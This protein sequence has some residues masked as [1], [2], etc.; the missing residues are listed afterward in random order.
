MPRLSVLTGALGAPKIGDDTRRAPEAL[1]RQSLSPG[2]QI[3]KNRSTGN[4]G[5]MGD[6][7]ER[8]RIRFSFDA[9]AAAA[10]YDSMSRSAYH[11]TAGGGGGVA[12]ENE[13]CR[14]RCAVKHLRSRRGSCRALTR[15][16]FLGAPS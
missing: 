3:P 14:C 12:C 1:A 13:A 9:G 2:L 8:A 10:E 11:R 7:S 6:S 5:T 16:V 15:L 4:L